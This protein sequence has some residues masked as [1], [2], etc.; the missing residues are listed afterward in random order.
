MLL[1][2]E[3]VQEVMISERKVGS[4]HSKVVCKPKYC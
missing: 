3:E 1:I 2:V 4:P